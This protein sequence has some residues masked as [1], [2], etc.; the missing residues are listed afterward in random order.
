[1]ISRKRIQVKNQTVIDLEGSKLH[2]FPINQHRGE[3]LLPIVKEGDY[4]KAGQ[5]IADTEELVSTPVHSSVSGTVK[6][7]TDEGMIVIENDFKN[8]IS[9][10]V[11][12]IEKPQDLKKREKLW[13]IRDAGITDSEIPAHIKF[14]P[15][16]QAQVLIITPSVPKGILRNR[17]II[18]HFQNPV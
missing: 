15:E 13:I 18:R 1:M 11:Q 3:P 6:E 10:T 17:K 5:K 7:V 14:N 12:P 16:H 9:E 8:E 4:V 2:Y